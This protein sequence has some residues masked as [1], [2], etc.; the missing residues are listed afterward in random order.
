MNL[1]Q[2][3]FEAVEKTGRAEDAD[4]TKVMWFPGHGLFR[5]HLPSRVVSLLPLGSE[6]TAL[7]V[8]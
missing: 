4:M 8:F 6:A 3:E 2:L 5:S 7:Q 1:K